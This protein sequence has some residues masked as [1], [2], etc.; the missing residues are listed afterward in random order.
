[1]KVHPAAELFP[2][3]SD[4]ELFALAADIKAN[5]LLQPLTMLGDVLLDGRNRMRACALAGVAPTTKQFTG[6]SPVAFVIAA[7]LRRRDLTASQKACIAVEIEPMFAEEARKRQEATRAK[8]GQQIGKVVAGLP[9]PTTPRR[10]NPFDEPTVPAAGTTTPPVPPKATEYTRQTYVCSCGVVFHSPV[11]HCP[12]CGAHE[13]VGEGECGHCHQAKEHMAYHATLF[14]DDDDN[15]L[16]PPPPP[17]APKARD[18]AAKTAGTSGRYVGEAKA[19][20]T[21]NPDAFE[22]VKAGAKTLSKATREVKKALAVPTM[23]TTVLP[24]ELIPAGFPFPCRSRWLCL[25]LRET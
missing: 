21:A 16:S 6:D 24:S 9:Q 13:G 7:N 2:I 11:W 25:R 5:G 19:L 4:D 14:A 3:M 23:E 12:H 1:V 15:E 8:P 17:A 18:L 10:P 22:A 20:K